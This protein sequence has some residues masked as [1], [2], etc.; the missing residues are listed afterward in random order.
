MSL[1]LLLSLFLSLTLSPLSL[2]FDEERARLEAHV[3]ELSSKLGSLEESSRA[4]RLEATRLEKELRQVSEAAGESQGSLNV[5]QDELVAFSEELA[6]LYNQ[7]GRAH[8]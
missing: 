7:I 8:V 1:S 2:L 6:N 5:A 4:E 3:Q